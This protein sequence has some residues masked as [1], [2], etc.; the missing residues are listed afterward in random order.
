ME[1]FSN[2]IKLFELVQDSIKLNAIQQVQ[3]FLKQ[4][5]SAEETFLTNYNS[6]KAEGV[7]YTSESISDFMVNQSILYFIK[8]YLVKKGYS[9]K[10]KLSYKDLL[11]L[12]CKYQII[13]QT[14]NI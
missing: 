6:R 10:K 13:I 7:Y 5:K 9:E 1:D 8:K 14:G 2:F 3:G 4:I 12:A 11:N